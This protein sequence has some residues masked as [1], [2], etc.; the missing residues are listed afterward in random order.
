MASRRLGLTST[1][2]SSTISS[3][4]PAYHPP[5]SSSPLL[6]PT[7]P[8][9]SSIFP[10]IQT[11]RSKQNRKLLAEK[12]ELERIMDPSYLGSSSSSS[13]SF[14]KSVNSRWNT[15]QHTDPEGYWHDID[16]R[17]F[18]KIKPSENE[19]KR[20]FTSSSFSS[21]S[22][23]CDY[24]ATHHQLPRRIN[25][26][27]KRSKSQEPLAYWETFTVLPTTP[28]HTTSSHLSNDNKEKEDEEEEEEEVKSE[29]EYYSTLKNRPFP[30]SRSPSPSPSS[31]SSEISYSYIIDDEHRRVLKK[32][33]KKTNSQKGDDDTVG[34]LCSNEEEI[35][36]RREEEEEREK[37]KL[38]IHQ[39]TL[40][41][42]K[43]KTLHEA[44]V[45][46]S[47]I[48]RLKVIRAQ[49]WLRKRVLS[50]P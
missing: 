44:W 23:S 24:W 15:C 34:N 50:C 32:K 38:T 28:S 4:P 36:T 21:R 9:T 48:T 20:S 8:S 40:K 16:Y 19:I 7:S 45:I 17:P 12:Q 35:V 29:Y 37:I 18:P 43:T 26:N 25:T 3:H 11:Q 39:S 41:N 6:S 30:R 33:K 27:A 42:S 2:S 31:S 13:S 10:S 5:P 1:L 14:S 46:M 47:F 22:E 49:R